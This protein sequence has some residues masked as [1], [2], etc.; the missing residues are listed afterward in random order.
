MGKPIH[1]IIIPLEDGEPSHPIAPPSPGYPDQGL[2]E[3]QPPHV[4]IWPRPPHVG[5][6]PVRPGRP[7]DPGFGWGGGE[8]PSTGPI[9]PGR[10]IDPGFGVGGGHHP[11]YP[12]QG[13]PPLPPGHPG[14]PGH[15]PWHPGGGHPD[16]GLP[17]EPGDP[18]HPIWIPDS[19]LKPD[20]GLP[21]TAPGEV[22]PPLG[23][24]PKPE[25]GF[26]LAYIPGVGYRY[27]KISLKPDQGLPG[28]KPPTAQPK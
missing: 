21:P 22:W 18:Q 9:R 11:D 3:P 25:S 10:P 28:G 17:G 20:Q 24:V 4:G 6:G 7:V 26:I 5:G 13:L 12:D 1:C 19:D 8:H 27:I 2:P 15:L 14:A 23:G 16:Q